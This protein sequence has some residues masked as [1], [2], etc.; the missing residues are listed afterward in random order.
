MP[1]ITRRIGLVL[2]LLGI[3]SYIGSGSK[4]PTALIPVAFG[5]ALVVLGRLA[6][7]PSR[8]KLM[9]HIA[10]TVGLL[11]FLAAGARIVMVIAR[12]GFEWRPATISQLLMAIIC[13]V[14]V[15][16]C[17]KSFVAARQT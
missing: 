5:F 13:A 3:T 4:S 10:V 1:Q 2:A 9:M 6:E 11:G 16:L 8:R 12:G 17:V 15:G 7:A 14:F